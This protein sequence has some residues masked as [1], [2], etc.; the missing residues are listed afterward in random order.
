MSAPVRGRQVEGLASTLR[1]AYESQSQ[2]LDLCA[3]ACD[4]QRSSEVR[5][6]SVSQG[7]GVRAGGLGVEASG[8]AISRR[9][10]AKLDQGQEPEASHRRVMKGIR[11][12][13]DHHLGATSVPVNAQGVLLKP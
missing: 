12:T 5:F 8:P 2:M 10:I 1:E 7:V 9:H 13:S 3:E 6:G 4:E 11:M